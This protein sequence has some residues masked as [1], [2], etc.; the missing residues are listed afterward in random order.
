MHSTLSEASKS[1]ARE[2]VI[3]DDKLKI[4]TIFQESSFIKFKSDSSKIQK[5]SKSEKVKLEWK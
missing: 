1:E 4:R 5:G 2:P 3:L